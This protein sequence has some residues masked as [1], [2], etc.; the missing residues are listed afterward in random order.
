MRDKVVF[1]RLPPLVEAPYGASTGRVAAER[2]ILPPSDVDL[3]RLRHVSQG[4]RP[5]VLSQFFR[6]MAGTDVPGFCEAVRGQRAS[7]PVRQG[8]AYYVVM[9]DGKPIAQLWLGDELICAG[10]TMELFVYCMHEHFGGAVVMMSELRAGAEYVHTDIKN[11]DLAAL[12]VEYRE[13]RRLSSGLNRITKLSQLDTI[14]HDHVVL[15]FEEA[16][17]LSSDE[18]RIIHPGSGVLGGTHLVFEQ[19]VVLVDPLIKWEGAPYDTFRGDKYQ[20]SDGHHY[21]AVISDAAAGDE[22]G[23]SGGTTIK[24]PGNSTAFLKLDLQD[25]SGPRGRP[26]RK[27]RPHNTEIIWEVD[28]EAPTWEE[29]RQ[30]LIDEVISANRRRMENFM[31]QVGTRALKPPA[32]THRRLN[33]VKHRLMRVPKPGPGVLSPAPGARPKISQRSARRVEAFAAACAATTYQDFQGW[34][35]SP[36]HWCLLRRESLAPGNISRLDCGFGSA[37][38][39]LRSVLLSAALYGWKTA[40]NGY[41]WLIWPPDQ[42]MPGDS[43]RQ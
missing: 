20:A 36:K 35:V 16:S 14:D 32:V 22:L 10:T 15:K 23:M 25:L 8:Y 29:Q 24:E 30:G 3:K 38:F 43:K 11:G 9:Q 28:D 4:I 37:L 13:A 34:C 1:S 19:P 31:R 39:A 7:V 12:L 27:P 41:G 33:F 18:I 6:L 2:V 21:D 42:R 17:Y 40:K 5:H 26:V